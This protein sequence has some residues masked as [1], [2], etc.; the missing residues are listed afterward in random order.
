[1]TPA[2]VET[3]NSFTHLGN[4]DDSDDDDVVDGASTAEQ[5]NTVASRIQREK[6]QTKG[7]ERK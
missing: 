7:R 5:L 2:P 4:D 3:N 1:M 6:S